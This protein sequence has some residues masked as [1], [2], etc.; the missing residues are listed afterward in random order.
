MSAS[1]EEQDFEL[2]V[3]V[4]LYGGGTVEEAARAVA[5]FQGTLD[6]PS[7]SDGGREVEIL[8][9]RPAS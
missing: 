5:G 4:R 8:S 7:T 3:K 6:L 9:A 1:D 2:L